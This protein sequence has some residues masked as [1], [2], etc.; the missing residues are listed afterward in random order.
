MKPKL[1]EQLLNVLNICLFHVFSFLVS[2]VLLILIR[3]SKSMGICSGL[4]MSSG[5]NLVKEPPLDG[6]PLHVSLVKKHCLLSIN[7]SAL[8]NYPACWC[9]KTLQE[10]IILSFV[11]LSGVTSCHLRPVSEDHITMVPPSLDTRGDLLSHSG[12]IQKVTCMRTGAKR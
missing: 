7:I 4:F 10:F 2:F 12:A 1:P 6:L 3:F 9:T 5:E 8:N 11:F